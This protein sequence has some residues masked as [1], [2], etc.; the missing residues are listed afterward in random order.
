MCT[1]NGMTFPA[2]LCIY[3]FYTYIYIY[4]YIYIYYIFRDTS[5]AFIV[6]NRLSGTTLPRFNI[7]LMENL[8]SG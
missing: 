1:I 2:A 4:I 8:V 5:Y 6:Q 7:G 3:I